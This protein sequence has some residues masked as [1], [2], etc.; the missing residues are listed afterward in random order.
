[1]NVLENRKVKELAL[2]KKQA[3][4]NTHI[5]TTFSLYT[6]FFD[7]VSNLSLRTEVV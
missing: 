2:K 3:N 7:P 6:L 1:M 5:S 4:K